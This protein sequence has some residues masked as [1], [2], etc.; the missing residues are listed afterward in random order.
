MVKSGFIRNV[1]VY[2]NKIGSDLHINAQEFGYQFV[3]YNMA[4][5]ASL[6]LIHNP[7][8][9]DRTIHREIDEITG[10]PTESQRITFLDFSSSGKDSNIQIIKKKDGYAFGYVR[11]MYGPYGPADSTEMAHSGDYYSM[12][13]EQNMGVQITDPTRCGELILA[14]A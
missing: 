12:H 4:N 11:G 13:I 1:E 10:Y 2:T 9:D 6:K 14:R 5:G 7:V 8:Y 3:K